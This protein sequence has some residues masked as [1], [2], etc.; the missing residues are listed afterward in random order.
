MSTVSLV[1][2][3]LSALSTAAGL[4][5]CLGCLNWL[6]VPLSLATAVAGLVGLATDRDPASGR[7]AN[8][9]VHLLA[10]VL[11]LLFA[12]VGAARCALGGGCV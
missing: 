6:A 4:P 9:Q 1:L 7:S 11:G 5:C 8:R 2:I 10:V 3:V 12:A